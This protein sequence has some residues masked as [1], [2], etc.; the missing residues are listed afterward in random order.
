M[1]IISIELAILLMKELAVYFNI[2]S[3]IDDKNQID[4]SFS[5]NLCK[6][7]FNLFISSNW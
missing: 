1:F 2:T 6:F 4:L 7:S 3:T 5:R